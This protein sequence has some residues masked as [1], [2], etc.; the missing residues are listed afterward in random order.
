MP[1]RPPAP[2]PKGKE[3][4]RSD[5]NDAEIIPASVSEPPDE[6]LNKSAGGTRQ[7][8]SENDPLKLAENQCSVVRSI[9][10]A[11]IAACHVKMVGPLSYEFVHRLIMT[12]F[13]VIMRRLS[14]HVQ[15]VGMHLSPALKFPLTTLP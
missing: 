7:A 10:N 4:A 14:R 2:T 5:S 11:N 13:R 3:R 9:L 8:S 6:V 1:P 12:A 15:N